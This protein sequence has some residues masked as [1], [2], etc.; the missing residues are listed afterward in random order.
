MAELFAVINPRSGTVEPERLRTRL[1]E[2][3]GAGCEI[4]ELDGEVD[5]SHL[6]REKVEVGA[7]AVLAAGGDGTVSGVADGLVHTDVPLGIIPLG[8][9]NGLARELQIPT[10]M[11]AACQLV[12]EMPAT[13]RID[14]LKVNGRYVLLRAGVGF[15]A[16]VIAATERQE[17]QLLGGLAYVWNIIKMWPRLRTYR[18][19]LT[20][21]GSAYRLSGIRHVALVN[22]ATLGA[23]GLGLTWGSHIKPDDGLID[24]CL[25]KKPALWQYFPLVWRAAQNKTRLDPHMQYFQARHTIHVETAV[26]L[27][28]HG[29][30]EIIGETP[31]SA[32]IVP[33]ALQVIVPKT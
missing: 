30:G 8:S 9:G 18:V 32:A 6:V 4:Y 21:D 24:V 16:D 11:E 1:G 33:A 2:L 28:I 26:P 19:T 14:A 5:L 12:R 27:P 3:F 15:E 25:I 7:T 10:E 17:K 13:R 31:L 20:L 29:D 23:P 22:G